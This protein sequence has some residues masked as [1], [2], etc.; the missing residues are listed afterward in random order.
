MKVKMKVMRRGSEG[1]H[2]EKEF[3]I[4]LGKRP[5]DQQQQKQ[6]QQEQ[7]QQ[8]Q[9]GNGDYGYYYDPFS[10]FED[11]FNNRGFFGW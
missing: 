7:Q 1:V 10:Q 5:V 9:Q 3:T 4:K 6:Q 2:E 11:F 8:Q